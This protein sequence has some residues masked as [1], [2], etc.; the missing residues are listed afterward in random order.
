M[1][2]RSGRALA[3]ALGAALV[4]LGASA[5]SEEA[6][7]LDRSATERAVE[8]VLG[9][10]VDADVADV[11]CPAEIERGVGR[12]FRCEASLDDDDAGRLRLR[13]RQ[14][15]DDGA[16]AIELL[17]AVVDPQDVATDLTRSLV[18]ELG[19]SFTVDCGAAGPLVVAPGHVLTCSVADATSEREV[20]VTVTDAAG[21]LA[22]DVGGP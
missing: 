6:T 12:R 19:R 18:E 7:T 22:Y 20:A 1:R 16:L 21:T 15:D 9:G 2:R 11:R 14:V 13:V 3:R 8:R 10:R 5:C 4:V 17:D